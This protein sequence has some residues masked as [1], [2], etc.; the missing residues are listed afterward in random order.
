MRLAQ[1]VL[2]TVCL[3]ALPLLFSSLTVFVSYFYSTS[4]SALPTNPGE[5][6]GARAWFSFPTPSALFPP[7]A[8]IGLT[9]DNSTFFLARP[10]AFGPPLPRSGLSGPLWIGSG[11][12]DDNARL[13]AGFGTSAEGELGCSDFLS[14]DHGPRDDLLYES[15]HKSREPA[16][17]GV[18]AGSGT[19]E[20]DVSRDEAKHTSRDKLASASTVH[21]R[22]GHPHDDGTDDYL[23]DALGAQKSRSSQHADI[24]SLQE[25]AEITGKVVLL[26]RGGCSFRE[27]VMWVQRRGGLA[28]IVGDDRRGGGLITM[29]ARGESRNV[30]IPSLFTSYTT[31]HLLSS[32]VPPEGYNSE[33]ATGGSIKVTTKDTGRKS[34]T[35]TEPKKNRIGDNHP[36]FTPEAPQPQA[37]SVGRLAN[38][39]NIPRRLKFDSG[40]DDIDTHSHISWFWK[41]LSLLG[42]KD[43]KATFAGVGPDSRRPPSS[44][45]LDWV[46]VDD[47]TGKDDSSGTKPASTS[48]AKGVSKSAAADGSPHRAADHSDDNGSHGDDFI[49]GVQDWRD[50][51]LVGS[52]FS[53][54]S[55]PSSE[56]NGLKSVSEGA[57]DSKPAAFRKDDHT[58]S[59]LAKAGTTGKSQDGGLFEGGV[60]TPGSGE[61][62]NLGRKESSDGSLHSKNAGNGVAEAK[63]PSKGH[64]SSEGQDSEDRDK[65]GSERADGRHNPQDE[66]SNSDG[67]DGIEHEGLWVTLTP[68]TMSTS[69]FFDTLLVLVVSPLVTLTV[70]YGMLLVRSRIRRRRWR[71]PKAVVD[72]LPVRTYHT[73]SS[74]SS[75]SLQSMRYS[76]PSSAS[77]ACPLLY[78]ESIS[79]APQRSRQGPT[80]SIYQDTGVARSWPPAAHE[81]PIMSAAEKAVSAA[82]NGGRRYV[83]RQVECVICLEEYVDGVSRV[84]SLPC[85]HE[86]H[87]ECITP[88]LTTRRRTCPICKGDVVRSLASRPFGRGASYRDDLQEDDEQP[89]GAG[90]FTERSPF[91]NRTTERSDLAEDNMDL[92]RADPETSFARAESQR[93]HGR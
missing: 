60:I 17:G 26:S 80:S 27:K 32:L 18:R 46:L 9:D 50:K 56:Q 78:S 5:Q 77:P 85:G 10:A 59:S 55:D 82:A 21:G 20:V 28:L 91:T 36:T 88:W 51:N 44:G 57:Q 63:E 33:T 64:T 69:P 1:L 3:A 16:R 35:H 58:A 74:S 68:T 70:V 67:S 72:R 41:I 81:A 86:F 39:A 93:I 83:G 37:T 22:I 84:M 12:G 31:A 11:F 25:S 29:Y 43:S 40:D 23:H 38:R 15:A 92:E 13:Q 24:Q 66:S 90:D 45:Q 42:L 53:K 4:D 75:S 65:A 19:S 34:E 30:S 61:Y 54:R 79:A 14:S 73:L 76:T 52:G 71:A 7:S 48:L 87:A 89:L 8:I 47:V 62:L 2:L 49:I 6:S